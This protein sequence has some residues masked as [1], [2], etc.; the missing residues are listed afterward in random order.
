MTAAEM[1]RARQEVERGA[2]Y[3]H[4]MLVN[5]VAASFLTL[6]V[7]AGYWVVSTLAG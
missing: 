3:D 4:R 7:I 6:L 2:E 1:S 5:F